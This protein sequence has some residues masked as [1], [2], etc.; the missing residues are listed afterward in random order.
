MPAYVVLI[1]DHIRDE[2]ALQ[3]YGPK[4]REARVGHALEPIAFYGKVRSLEGMPVD[5]AVILQFPSFEEAEAWY[6]SPLYQEARDVRLKGGDY[7]AFII[8]G[9][10]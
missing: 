10:G 5:G 2:A 3:A 6:E 1:R 9:V 4:A 7:R 8:D